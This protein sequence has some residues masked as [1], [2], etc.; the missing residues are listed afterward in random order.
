MMPSVTNY[1]PA[2][3]M[4]PAA[5]PSHCT[6]EHWEQGTWHSCSAPATV[7][8]LRDVDGPSIVGRC[9]GHRLDNYRHLSVHGSH[10]AAALALTKEKLCQTP[11]LTIPAPQGSLEAVEC[12][13]ILWLRS[14]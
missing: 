1:T 4:S 7:F 8:Y 5:D 3:V 9:S 14:L 12:A 13:N 6:A 2:D 11:N 10:D